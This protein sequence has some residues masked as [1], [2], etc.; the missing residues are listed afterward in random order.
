MSHVAFQPICLVRD[1]GMARFHYQNIPFPEYSF[2]EFRRQRL[3]TG[4]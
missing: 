4:P 3:K 1:H 2:E